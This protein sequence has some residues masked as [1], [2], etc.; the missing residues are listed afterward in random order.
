MRSLILVSNEITKIS[1]EFIEENKNLCKPM[2]KSSAPYSRRDR[3]ARRQEVYR[4][5]FELGYF[6][7][8]IAEMMKINRNTINS[9]IKYWYS[10][11]ARDWN[12]YD[13]SAWTVKQLNR[14][15]T[16]RS[17]LREELEKQKNLEDKLSIERL[18]LEIDDR[19]SKIMISMVKTADSINE[20]AI[21]Q[22]NDWMEQN[23]LDH[24]F[25]GRWSV[26]KVSKKRHDKIKEILRYRS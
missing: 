8:K 7:V 17:R 5:H 10:K 26:E 16:Q 23:K 11:L 19:I 3:F 22:I 14:L 2:Q 9:D 24:R 4:L 13:I 15:E 6:A 21:S 20:I 1:P 18:I 25:I 12:G